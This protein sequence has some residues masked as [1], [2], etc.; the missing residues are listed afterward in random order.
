MKPP[1]EVRPKYGVNMTDVKQRNKYDSGISNQ[2]SMASKMEH[3]LDA[4]SNLINKT[5]NNATVS[6]YKKAL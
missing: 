2:F 4:A 5:D 6:T 1:K 3:A